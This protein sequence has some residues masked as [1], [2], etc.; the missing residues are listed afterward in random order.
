M[1][2]GMVPV[3]WGRSLVRRAYARP[4]TMQG[5][6]EKAHE[7]LNAPAKQSKRPRTPPPKA[8]AE[9]ALG[10]SRMEFE[11]RI[12]AETPVHANSNPFSVGAQAGFRQTWMRAAAHVASNRQKFNAT[13]IQPALLA[14]LDAFGLGRVPPGERGSKQQ[15]N[16]KTRDDYLNASHKEAEQFFRSRRLNFLGAATTPASFLPASDKPVFEVAFAG[17]SNVGK[18]TLIN[19]LTKSSPARSRNKP[20]VTQSINFYR[21]TDQARVVDFPGYGFAFANEAKQSLWQDAIRAYLQD[22]TELE[23]VY[24][25]LGALGFTPTKKKSQRRDSPR[26]LDYTPSLMSGAC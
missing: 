10:L 11:Q 25:V 23:L 21:V 22:R 17:R 20:G 6:L 18:S 24:L 19:L 16:V 3:V 13:P 14:K 1:R 26:V 4:A 9:D 2:C 12:M 5:L 15:L 7:P 8:D